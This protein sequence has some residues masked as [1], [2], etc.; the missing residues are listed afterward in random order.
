MDNPKDRIYIDHILE[1]IGLIEGFIAG[2]SLEEF[3]EDPLLYSAVTRQIEVIGEAAKR[4][5]EEIKTK[6]SALP[7]RR[8]SGMRDVL[9]HDYMDVDLEILWKAAT[10]DIRELK[11]IL[12]KNSA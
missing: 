11:E 6:F 3:R 5:S 1:A 7:W 2:K 8:I 4:L 9:I 12:G 10:E